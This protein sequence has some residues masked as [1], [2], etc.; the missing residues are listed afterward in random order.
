MHEIITKLKSKT[1]Y[2][3]SIKFRFLMFKKVKEFCLVKLN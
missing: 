3:I 2:Q 1:V